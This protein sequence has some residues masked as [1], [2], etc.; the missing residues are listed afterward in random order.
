MLIYTGEIMSF[1]PSVGAPN[2]SINLGPVKFAFPQANA[3]GS[4]VVNT[5]TVR[6]DAAPL[7][8]AAHSEACESYYHI[9]L[10]GL[11]FEQ[12]FFLGNDD[13]LE[14]DLPLSQV[15]RITGAT[16]PIAE[17]EIPHMRYFRWICFF[18]FA[19]S[20]M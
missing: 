1:G 17:P 9:E 20:L 6:A 8:Q 12:A 15:N 13:D 11:I 3:T 2:F 14:E 4:N 5:T 18:I 7:L 16:S 10:L 19:D